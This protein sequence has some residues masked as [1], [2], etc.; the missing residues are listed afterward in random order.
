MEKK[1]LKLLSFKMTI[2]SF[3]DFMKKVNKKND[4]MN[5]GD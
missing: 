4:T 5:E 2:F 3:D 1:L